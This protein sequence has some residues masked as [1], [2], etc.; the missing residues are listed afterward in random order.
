MSA[1]SAARAT[2]PRPPTGPKRHLRGKL[3]IA[4]EF[5]EF[6]L[7]YIYINMNIH[8][9]Y[10]RMPVIHVYIYIHIYISDIREKKERI[11]TKER[12]TR[13]VKTYQNSVI[14]IYTWLV[15]VGKR[16]FIRQECFDPIPKITMNQ[17]QQA[18]ALASWAEQ[19]PSQSLRMWTKPLCSSSTPSCAAV[20]SLAEAGPPQTWRAGWTL[21]LRTKTLRF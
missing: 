1:A 5:I 17:G 16:M 20:A 11:Y 13:E 3:G 7:Y 15:V 2:D 14:Y 9:I 8:V 19:L 12:R 6:P 21:K 18:T 10:V 4:S